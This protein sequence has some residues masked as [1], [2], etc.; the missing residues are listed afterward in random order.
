MGQHSC[1][2]RGAP[3]LGLLMDRDAD[4]SSRTRTASHPLA[5]LRGAT[6]RSDQIRQRRARNP[7]WS[8]TIMALL[9]D[10]GADIDAQDEHGCTPPHRTLE[11]PRRNHAGR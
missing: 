6:I 10:E 2:R 3:V 9:P 7:V 11:R 4:V 5:C 1:E 8:W